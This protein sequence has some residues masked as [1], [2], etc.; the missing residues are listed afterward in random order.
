MEGVTIYSKN[1]DLNFIIFFDETLEDTMVDNEQ[2]KT[3]T[4]HSENW[5]I[6]GDPP[7]CCLSFSNCWT[8]ENL[9][10][11]FWSLCK[12][13]FIDTNAEIDVLFWKVKL[14]KAKTEATPVNRISRFHGK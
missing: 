3:R 13:F 4:V 5:K 10:Q 6:F 7:Y 9:R 2:E 8:T 14:N 11:F 12:V 1:L